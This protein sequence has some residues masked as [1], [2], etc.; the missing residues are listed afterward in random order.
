MNAV[1][2]DAL[3]RD[4][5]LGAGGEVEIRDESGT[6]IGRFT[7]LTRVGA[8]L[9]EGEMPS[10]EELDRRAR[11]GKRYSVAEVEER[12]RKLKEAIG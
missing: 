7:K 10:A 2:V 3:T 11:E 4:R 12:L 1:V 8:Y 5:L 6:V 9:I